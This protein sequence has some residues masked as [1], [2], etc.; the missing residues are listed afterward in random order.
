MYIDA[1][2][3]MLKTGKIESPVLGIF[4]VLKNDGRTVSIHRND[5]FKRINADRIT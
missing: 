1:T 4:R 2:D 5:G 3:G